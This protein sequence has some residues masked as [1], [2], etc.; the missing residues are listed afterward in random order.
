ML[1]KKPIKRGNHP[2]MIQIPLSA[3]RCI[4]SYP[5]EQK[6]ICEI[7]LNEFKKFNEPETL[8]EI[9]NESRLDYALGNYKTFNNAKKLIAELKS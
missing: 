6:I 2:V 4:S 5:K 8:D 7:H 3:L 9:I 1:T